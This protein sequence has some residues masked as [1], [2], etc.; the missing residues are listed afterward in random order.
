MRNLVPTLF[1][2]WLNGRFRC[3]SS[4][5]RLPF[6][7]KRPKVIVHRGDTTAGAPENSLSAFRHGVEVSGAHGFECDIRRAMD[8]ALV[9]LH[10]PKVGR[11]AAPTARSPGKKRWVRE[12]TGKELRTFRLKLPLR[13]TIPSL[14]EVLDYVGSREGLICY[15][16][17][18]EGNLEYIRAI[19]ETVRRYQLQDRVLFISFDASTLALAKEMAPEIPGEVIV[20]NIF[21]RLV[22][23]ARAARADGVA[24]AVLTFRFVRSWLQAE[25]QKAHEAGLWVNAGVV[26]SL[27]FLPW[28]LASGI[29]GIFTDDPRLILQGLQELVGEGEAGPS[30]VPLI[31]RPEA[32]IRPDFDP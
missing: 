26:N 22:D 9:I 21:H 16:E 8:G 4:E 6:R 17:F 20:V 31:L 29:D 27:H 23:V 19:I 13:E 25:V 15:L 2:S 24:I 12:L 1:R 28:L 14:E 5:K 32:D 11:T 10:D 18:K 30:P 7:L 3:I